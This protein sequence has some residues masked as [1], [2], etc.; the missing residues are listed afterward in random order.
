MKI[1]LKN[2]HLMGENCFEN[3]HLMGKNSFEKTHKSLKSLEID[4][5]HK[6]HRGTFIREN[7]LNLGKTIRA[8]GM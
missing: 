4:S 6:E 5:R 2:N 3:N 7:L 1:V 8:C